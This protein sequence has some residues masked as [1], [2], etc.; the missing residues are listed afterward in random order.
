[1]GMLFLAGILFVTLIGLSYSQKNL[2][3][4]YAKSAEN[5]SARGEKDVADKKG[6]IADRNM[7]YSKTSF[8]A[9]F[10]IAGIFI[11]AA[12]ITS[13]NMA[14]SEITLYEKGLAGIT[15]LPTSSSF[16]L[17]YDK[18]TTMKVKKSMI[19]ICV[20]GASYICFTATSLVAAE[21]QRII[22]E[23]QQK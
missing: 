4:V 17:T 19:T 6:E 5:A 12:V 23:Q 18:V 22:T 10:I 20:S 9:S 16:Q 2:A 13:G 21:I 11:V 3:D 1:M 15:G 14:R 8:L 7:V